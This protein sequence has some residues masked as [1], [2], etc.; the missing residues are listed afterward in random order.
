MRAA[1]PSRAAVVSAGLALALLGASPAAAQ[2]PSDPSVNLAVAVAPNMQSLPVLVPSADGGSI[3]LWRGTVTRRSTGSGS[4]PRAS[5]N[6]RR[7]DSRS[8][9]HPAAREKCQRSPTAA[10]A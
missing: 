9:R 6:G 7:T 1:I 5:H 4:M 10:A 3:A 8:P 2:W